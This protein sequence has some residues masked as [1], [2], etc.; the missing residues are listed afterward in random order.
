MVVMIGGMM[1]LG[2]ACKGG[3]DDGDGDGGGR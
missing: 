3:G 2:N 1:V